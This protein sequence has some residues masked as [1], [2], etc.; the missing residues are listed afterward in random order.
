MGVSAQ[1][2]R[3]ATGLFHGRMCSSSW[4]SCT[5]VYRTRGGRGPDVDDTV[6]GDWWKNLLMTVVLCTTIFQ[7]WKT[8]SI[9][10]GQYVVDTSHLLV[11]HGVVSGTASLMEGTTLERTPGHIRMLLMLAGDVESNPGPQS[12]D[13]V[14][15]DGLAELVGQAPASMWEVLFVWGQD[16]PS[17]E[18][19]SELGSRKFT[20]ALQC[21][22]DY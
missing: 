18:I 17:N 2:H 13:D 1:Q 8:V 15:I 9:E 10:G 5:G 14:L 12:A 21:L 4:S 16:K 19:F 7:V 20:V 22:L 6:S 3:M 11:S